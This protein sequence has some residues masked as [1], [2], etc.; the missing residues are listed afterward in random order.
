MPR[1]PLPLGAYGKIKTWQDGPTWLARAKFRDFDGVVRLVKRSG[2]SKAA[3]ER[4]L[5]AALVER[6]TPVKEAEITPDT[7]FCKV[8]ESWLA[9]VEKAVDVGSRSPGTLDAYR[10]IYGR[11]VKAALG[12][13]R[14]REVGTPVVDRVLGAIKQKTVSGARTAK[15]V[16]SGVM[17]LAARHGA[18]TI[19]PVREAARIEGTPR[20]KPR[21]LTAEERRQWLDLLQASEPARVWDLPDLTVMMLATGCRIGECLA[22]GWDEVDLDQAAVDV[23]WRLVRRTGVGLLRL[24]STKSGESGERLIPLP[25]WAVTMLK[26]RRLAIGPEVQ[27]VFPDSL[28]GWRDPSNVRRV[29]RQVRDQAELDGLVSHMLR[30]TVASFLDDADVSTRKISDPTRGPGATSRSPRS[31]AASAST[32][33][34][35]R[36]ATQAVAADNT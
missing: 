11:H 24:P 16:I 15:I 34:P 21:A 25:S 8:A 14:I 29:W 20:R 12:E 33:S 4:A 22:L 19:N 28:G 26:R 10:Y 9:E 23:R 13:L 27:P 31:A 36:Q 5:R 18:V 17:R 32:Q 6:Q 7:K 35:R 2:K 3:A 1:P 30:K